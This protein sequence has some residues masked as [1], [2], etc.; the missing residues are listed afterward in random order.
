MLETPLVWTP[1]PTGCA[2]CW[3]TAPTRCA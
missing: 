2:W 3:P 1:S